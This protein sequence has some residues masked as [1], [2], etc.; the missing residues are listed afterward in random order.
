MSDLHALDPNSWLETVWHA[1]HAYR[2]DCIPESDE[3]YDDEW[4]DICTAMHWIDEALKEVAITL[5]QK[6][7]TA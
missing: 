3:T 1:L 5:N 2:E 7:T 4:S 6:E